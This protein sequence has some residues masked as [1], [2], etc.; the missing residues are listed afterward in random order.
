MG[1]YPS[2]PY[3]LGLKAL[4][5][6]LEKWKGLSRSP[7]KILLTLNVPC[8]SESCTEINIK[9]NFYFHTSL[10]RLKRFF[11]APQISEKI[12]T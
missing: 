1:L 5:E 8:I 9:L 10:W 2:I 12:K 3:E 7:M 6:A 11:K 4:K